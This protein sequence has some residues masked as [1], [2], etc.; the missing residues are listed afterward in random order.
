MNRTRLRLVGTLR[1][2]EVQRSPSRAFASMVDIEGLAL[3]LRAVVT[4]K[5]PLRAPRL[6]YPHGDI[7]LIESAIEQRDL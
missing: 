6:R 7:Y 2:E 4:P 1:G 3:S 5:R